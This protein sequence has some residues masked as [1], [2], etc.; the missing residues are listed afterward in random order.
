[1]QLKHTEVKGFETRRLEKIKINTLCLC[2]VNILPIRSH[3]IHHTP[4]Y[5]I[6]LQQV[7]LQDKNS[8]IWEN[9]TNFC[10]MKII[11]SKIKRVKEEECTLK[12]AFKFKVFVTFLRHGQLQHRNEKDSILFCQYSLQLMKWLLSR[13]H[14]TFFAVL[15][16]QLMFIR[17]IQRKSKNSLINLYNVC[18]IQ[19]AKC[20]FLL[21]GM[22]YI[23]IKTFTIQ[24]KNIA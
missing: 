18:S 9:Q 14:L 17:L 8:T 4:F 12:H 24:C 1:M 6:K 5:S 2:F 23:I 19:I 3:T 13:G 7:R 20:F 15:L 11:P 21:V 16:Q 22:K 10:L